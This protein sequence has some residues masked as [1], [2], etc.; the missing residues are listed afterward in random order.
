MWTRSN[1][2]DIEILYVLRTDPL[3][4]ENEMGLKERASVKSGHPTTLSPLPTIHPSSFSARRTF[5]LR[6]GCAIAFL[7]WNAV[8]QILIN[9]TYL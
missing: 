1:Q 5:M 3:T 7:R 2:G 6:W 8:L 9:Q 4:K